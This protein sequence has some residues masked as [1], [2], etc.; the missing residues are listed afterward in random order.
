VLL[1]REVVDPRQDV[2]VVHH[3]RP[4]LSVS[5]RDPSRRSALT[6]RAA[7]LILEEATVRDKLMR[8]VTVMFALAIGLAVP[9]ALVTRGSHGSPSEPARVSSSALLGDDL[10]RSLGLK[11]ITTFPV[12]GCK[13]FAESHDAVGYCLD[14][15]VD[16]AHDAAMRRS[17]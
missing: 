4:Y 10:A 7:R 8:L 11:Q 12:I 1:A 15:V 3:D 17:R 16:N 14:D 6:S 13:Y 9:A 5:H 2:G